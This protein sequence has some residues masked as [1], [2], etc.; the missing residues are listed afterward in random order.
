MADKNKDWT[1][2]IHITEDGDDTRAEAV[3]TTQ[4]MSQGTSQDT[5]TIT[6]RGVAHRNPIDRP[7]PEIGDELAASRALEDLAIRLHDIASDDIVELAGPVDQG[8][9]RAW[10]RP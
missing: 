9:S 7:I 1:V 3:L 8:G 4:E 6:G 2:R 5:S 10:E